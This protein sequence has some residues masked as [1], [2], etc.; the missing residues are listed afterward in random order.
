V[1]VNP[2]SLFD[3][4]LKRIHE[5]KRQHLNALYIL[6]LYLRLK[7]DPEA[8]VPPRTFISVARQIAWCEPRH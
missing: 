5:Y 6:A 1:D 3:I 4:Q 2:E 8:Y 7:R